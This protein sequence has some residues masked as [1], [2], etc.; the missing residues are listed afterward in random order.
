[1]TRPGLPLSSGLPVRARDRGGPRRA[2]RRVAGG[3]AQGEAGL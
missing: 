1:L 2:G 3:G